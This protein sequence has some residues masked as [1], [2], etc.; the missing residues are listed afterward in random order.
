MLL[1]ACAPNNTY[2]NWTAPD[3]SYKQYNK[4][5]IFGLS[6]DLQDANDFE[7][8]T[9]NQLRKKGYACVQGMALLPPEWAKDLD[10]KTIRKNLLS[11]GVEG[12]LSL[13][14]VNVSTRAVFTPDATY[15]VPY[16]RSRF[17]STYITTYQEIYQ[18]G[19]YSEMSNFIYEA[20]FYDLTSDD[21]DNNLVWTFQ[22][23]YDHAI[24]GIPA[25]TPFSKTLLDALAKDKIL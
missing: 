7:I 8:S 9:F 22:F 24:P 6:K 15:I 19:Y 11:K 13:A 21:V 20:H 16:S 5:A 10:V 4:I 18:K 23:K 1:T 17:G 25:L 2:Y 3:Y 12:V 14:V